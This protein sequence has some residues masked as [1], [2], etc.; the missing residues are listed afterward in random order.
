V[1]MPSSGITQHFADEIDQI[2]DL[3]VGTRLPSFDDD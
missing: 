1:K 2:L 3:A